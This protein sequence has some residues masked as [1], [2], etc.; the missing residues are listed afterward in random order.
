MDK[1]IIKEAVSEVLN[2]RHGIDSKTHAKHHE[3]IDELISDYNDRKKRRDRIKTQIIG[4]AIIS[5][6]GSIA[7]TIGYAAIELI[8]NTKGVG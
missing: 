5:I 7:Y 8:K 2:E 1:A 6:A 4:W 3:Y